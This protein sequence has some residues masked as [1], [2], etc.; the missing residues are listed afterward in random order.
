MSN[1]IILG[2]RIPQEDP[3]VKDDTRNIIYR[4]VTMTCT[5]DES[6]NSKYFY[7]AFY[8]N[9]G[10]DIIEDQNI[11]EFID[12]LVEGGPLPI[13]RATTSPLDLN[14]KSD[15]YIVFH[16]DPEINWQFS[17]SG[18]CFTT[19]NDQASKYYGL[20]QV[21]WDGVRVPGG[22]PID[23]YCRI[24]YFRARCKNYKFRDGFNLVIDLRLGYDD[25]GNE[26]RTKV[27]LD[28]DIRNPGG[29]SSRRTK[30]R[31]APREE[32]SDKPCTGK[33]EEVAAA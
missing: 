20:H 22:E 28:P 19:K 15:C 25:D 12:Y 27:V 11:D 18:D 29:S 24:L 13:E 33:R 26:R 31:V 7:N 2:H 1:E 9:D 32:G 16:L 30:R 17:T 14:C 6:E 5:E 10:D 21:M 8:A 3:T 4:I 23:E